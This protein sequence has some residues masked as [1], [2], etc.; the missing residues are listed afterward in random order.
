MTGI[1]DLSRI[2]NENCGILKSQVTFQS[3]AESAQ[4][5]YISVMCLVYIVFV[6]ISE[7]EGLTI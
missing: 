5:Q 6:A 7:L 3:F 4:P 1:N 2:Q